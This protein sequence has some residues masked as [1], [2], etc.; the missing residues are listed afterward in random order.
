MPAT[1]RWVSDLAGTMLGYFRL[2]STGPRL[3][4]SGANLLVRNP[5]DS[6]DAAITVSTVNVSGNGFT[7][8]S[9][10]AGSGADW[11][12]TINRPASGMTAAVTLTLPVDDGT[13]G[14]VLATDG[15]G[16]LSWVSAASTDAC[17]KVDST[18]LA[19]NSS[20]TVA[21][22][23]LPANAQ[24]VLVRVYVDTAFNATGPATM[25]VGTAGSASKYMG[26]TSVDLTTVGSYEVTPGEIPSGST[27]AIQIAFSAGTSASA[28]AARVEVHYAIPA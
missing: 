27:E 16:N 7:I 12:Y 22:L 13:N 21:M 8:N 23:T 15:S 26:A 17:V 9:D 19:H 5:G 6:A 11:A 25:S 14:Q 20:S 4:A 2:G 18:A 10:A 1:P 28:G 3:K 24:V